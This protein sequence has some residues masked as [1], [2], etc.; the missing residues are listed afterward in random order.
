MLKSEW[1]NVISPNY[2]AMSWY[3]L[4]AKE[5]VKDTWGSINI[6]ALP[7]LLVITQLILFC[8]I[9]GSS[10]CFPFL[11]TFLK[12]FFAHFSDRLQSPFCSKSPSVFQRIPQRGLLSFWRTLKNK[13][14][15]DMEFFSD[16]WTVNL[17]LYKPVFRKWHH[18]ACHMG[19]SITHIILTIGHFLKQWITFIE[20]EK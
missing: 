9:S 20:Y 7:T 8:F 17:K 11:I 3:W 12:I 18:N 10:F 14:N 1:D 4:C 2:A 6:C 16:P 19:I 13:V 5:Y 15:H